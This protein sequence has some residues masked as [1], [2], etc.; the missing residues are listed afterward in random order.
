[1]KRKHNKI[2]IVTAIT[3]LTTVTPTSLLRA[4]PLEKGYKT[5]CIP[6]D[7]SDDETASDSDS[8]GSVTKSNGKFKPTDFKIPDLG[9]D[10]IQ[11]GVPA[12]DL[13]KKIAKA[14]GDATGI[15]P[16]IIFA[17]MGHETSWGSA[18]G[19]KAARDGEHNL[20]GIGYVSGTPGVQQGSGHGEGDGSYGS[21][22]SWQHY[23]MAYASILANMLNGHDDAKKDPKAFVHVLKE[24]GYY[25]DSESNY[26]AGFMSCMSKWDSSGGSN[27]ALD[28]ANEGNAS[29]NNNTSSSSNN[30]FEP[31]YCSSN[32]NQSSNNVSEASGSIVD[33]ARKMNGWF[34]YSQTNRYN[35]MKD[36]KNY[37]DLKSI[38][39]LNKDGNTDCS[40]FVWIVLK[41]SG[42]KVPDTPW[43][44]PLQE[45]DATGAHQYLKKIDPKD[46]KAGD[47][48][49]VNVG[50]GSGSMGHTAILTENWHGYDTKC[51][52]EGGDDETVFHHDGVCEDTIQRQFGSLVDNGRVT[53]A[54]PI[55]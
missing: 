22:D 39:Q 23:A 32:S 49:I 20:T 24:K 6:D 10:K 54:R 42:Y 27:Q 48:I 21:Y 14:V 13:C 16:K 3:I 11:E 2:L 47:V 7:S 28:L 41:V 46:A 29:D 53:I 19:A 30:S 40:G 51:I 35:F 25:T 8:S 55:K 34:H 45:S 44:T 50:G 4:S 5:V 15:D 12:Y 36:G 1:M 52:N 18:P 17:Q 38:D 31:P 26:L 9:D 43:T 33:N 37:K